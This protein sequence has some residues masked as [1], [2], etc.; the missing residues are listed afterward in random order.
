[1]VRQIVIGLCL[2]LW[3]LN[4]YLNNTLPDFI[5]YAIPSVLLFV[6][7]IIYK[8]HPKYYLLPILVIGLVEP[9]L[10][11]FPIIFCVFEI[12]SKFT[13]PVFILLPIAIIIF[14]ISFK[15]FK[16][17][18]VFH[19]DHEAE[20]QIVLNISAYPNR[21][22]ARFFQNKSRI[23][24]DKLAGNFFALTDLN[25]Y[26]FG[27]HPRP[28]AVNNQNLFKYPFVAIVFFLYGLFYIFRSKESRFIVLSVVA[29]LISLSCLN[30]FDRIDFILWL[31]VSLIII[32]G[33]NRLSLQNPKL[34]NT[35]SAG[36]IIFAI[37]EI[38]RG[39]AWKNMIKI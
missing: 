4:L 21:F 20:Q 27:L 10:A 9:K 30:N 26:F 19:K 5:S 35:I 34:F 7:F 12:I 2:L 37:P 11:F 1:M 14:G 17:Q 39:F 33:V 6:S 22:M 3:P 23:Y 32:Y 24:T 31:P 29:S 28:I 16:G 38:V 36:L 25:N 13:K 18:T 8:K 15:E